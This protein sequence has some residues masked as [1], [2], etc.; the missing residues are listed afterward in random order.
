MK[1]VAWSMLTD[2]RR[3]LMMERTRR[4]MGVDGI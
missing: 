4:M 2:E 1:S 3:G